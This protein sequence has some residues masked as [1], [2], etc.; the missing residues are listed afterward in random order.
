VWV[1]GPEGNYKDGEKSILLLVGEEI[2]DQARLPQKNHLLVIGANQELA[3]LAFDPQQLLDT[4]GRVGGLT[5]FAHPYDPAAPAVNEP[6]LSWEDWDLHG[7]TGIELWNSMSE[8]K[9]LLKSKFHAIFYAFN[10][11]RVARGPFQKTLQKWDELLA[12]G[13]KVVAIGGSDAHACKYS[14]GP[15]KRIL[16]P[17]KFHFNTVNTHLL[18]T[19]ELS[20]EVADDRKLILEA[21]A[22]G[23]AF[24]GYDLP[25]PT[26]GFRFT[27]HGKENSSIMGEEVSAA[28][29]VTFQIHLPIPVECRLLKDGEVVKTWNNRDNCIYITSEPG[30]YRTE[31]FI[32]YLGRR[33][34]WIYSNPIYVSK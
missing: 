2:H 1:R 6:D 29:G 14:L 32:N 27:A 18:L 5:F 3:Q 31:A 7:Y 12:N 13:Q 9:S 34:G 33:R 8:F 24:I 11:K 30:V 28:Y 22:N 15:L 19:E 17:Y 26:R 25:A 20:G 4:V 10:P 23:Q 21:L 16:F